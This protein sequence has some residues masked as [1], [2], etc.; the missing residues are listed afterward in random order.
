MLKPINFMMWMNLNIV[1]NYLV[2]A[3]AVLD[4]VLPPQSELNQRSMAYAVVPAKVKRGRCLGP[5]D[6]RS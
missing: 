5:A 2:M 4:A 1:H 3:K 6:L